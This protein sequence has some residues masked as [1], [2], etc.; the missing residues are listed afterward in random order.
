MRQVCRKKKQEKYR[1]LGKSK[2]A[3]TK[4]HASHFIHDKLMAKVRGTSG[5][6]LILSIGLT[7]WVLTIFSTCF[8]STSKF[9]FP[10]KNA[11][12]QIQE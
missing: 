5:L 2:T 12:Q 10:V 4:C 9:P 11:L 7:C 8:I 6:C 3:G 1:K